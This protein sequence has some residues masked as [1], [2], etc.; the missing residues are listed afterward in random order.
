MDKQKWLNIQ[1]D[2][3]IIKSNLIELRGARDQLIKVKN[4]EEDKIVGLKETQKLSNQ[5]QLFLLSEITDRRKN[6]I[7]S[8]EKM[9]TFALR[10]VYGEGYKLRFNTFEEK[11]KEGIGNFKMEINVV[12]PFNG[13]EL[14]TGLMGERGGGV[15]EI[16]AFAL[17]IAALNWAHYNG[18]LILD[19]AYKSMSNDDKLQSV[20]QF[21]KE[22]SSQTGRQILFATHRAETFSKVA[23]NI[24]LVDKK[25]GIAQCT[26]VDDI[27]DLK[28]EEEEW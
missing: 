19:E 9:G 18:P 2:L 20:A 23:D 21:L 15:I 17:R 14:T 3:G 4:K 22:V 5:A 25:D 12:S 26:C 6:A 1:K 27:N 7:D 13:G 10:L 8:I 24:V 11:R 28:N 16:V